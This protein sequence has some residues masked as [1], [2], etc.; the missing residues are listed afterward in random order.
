MRVSLLALALNALLP[1]CAPPAVGPYVP[2]SGLPPLEPTLSSIQSLVFTPRCTTCHSASGLAPDLTDG[3]SFASLVSQ[4]SSQGTLLVS[5]GVP[6]DSELLLRVQPSGARPMPP[7]DRLTDAE[8][9]A[10]SDWIF[11]GAQDD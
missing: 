10:I 4:P 2:G 9:Q 7:G 1:A 3:A 11:N 6:Q 8:V 5:P